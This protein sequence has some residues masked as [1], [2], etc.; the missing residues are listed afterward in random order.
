VGSVFAKLLGRY[1]AG[2][3]GRSV[4]GVRLTGLTLRQV[5]VA[6]ATRGFV[7]RHDVIVAERNADGA[8]Q[9]LRVD[10]SPTPARDDPQLVPVECFVHPDGGMIR[11]FPMGDPRGRVAPP[12][13]TAIKSVLFVAGDPSTTDISFRNEAFRVTDG[14][15]AVPKSLRTVYGLR[16]D[17]YSALASYKL[18]VGVIRHVFLPLKLDSVQIR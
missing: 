10:G 15:R 11:V 8:P 12:Q 16:A 1:N 3:V 13:P 17:P 18:A 4:S 2:E 7:M 6:L 14:G 5:N 9:W